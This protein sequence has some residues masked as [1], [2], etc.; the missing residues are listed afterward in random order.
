LAGWQTFTPVAYGAQSALQHSPQLVHKTPSGC[1]MQLLRPRPIGATHVP[2]LAPLAS[3]QMPV[4]QSLS[5]AQ[6][7][8]GWMQLEELSWQ[9]PFVHRPEQHSPLPPHVL[10]AVLQFGLSGVHVPP[11]PHVPPQH[12]A[13][14]V[15][16]WLSD[17]HCVEP[18]MPPE[19]T[20][21]QQSVAAVHAPLLEQWPMFGPPSPAGG[22]TTP[23]SPVP[24][25]SAV[26]PSLFPM[27]AL[28]EPQATTRLPE[29]QAITRPMPR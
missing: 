15:Q 4:Q 27:V 3:W 29:L 14:A 22:M 13:F 6:T 18:H 16:A 23:P 11:A 7:S 19:Q 12:C 20:S 28:L 10:P 24:P 17:V 9:V 2:T 21:V 25:P 5:W 26:P 8:P 1:P